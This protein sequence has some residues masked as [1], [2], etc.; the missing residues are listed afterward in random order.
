MG[1]II[2]MLNI[3]LLGGLPSDTKRNPREHVKAITL[4]NG[5]ELNAPKPHKKGKE[6]K[7][8]VEKE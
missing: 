8:L 4:K 6:E 2:N 7:K 5:K 3:R 1:Q